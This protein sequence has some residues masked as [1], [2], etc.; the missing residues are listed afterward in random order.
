MRVSVIAMLLLMVVIGTGVFTVAN[1]VQQA[2]KKI[3]SLESKIATEKESLRVLHAEWTFLNNPS[4]LEKVARNYFK[5][6][7]SDGTQYIT[8]ASIPLRNSF[9]EPEAENDE[10]SMLA[11]IEPGTPVEQTAK[12]EESKEKIKITRVSGNGVGSVLPP[13]A[14]KPLPDLLP[15]PISA[16]QGNVQ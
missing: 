2:E 6:V 5:L 1:R 15:T 16:P 10:A 3:S 11:E 7:P 13:T 4:R 12:Q 14:T 9:P 8:V